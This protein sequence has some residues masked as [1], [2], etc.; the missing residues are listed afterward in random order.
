MLVPGRVLRR[1][2]K[3][4]RHILV[5]GRHA[6]RQTTYVIAGRALGEIFRP[7]ELGL[8][9]PG[10]VW[11][12]TV[13]LLERP[14]PAELDASTPAELLTETWRRLFRA[15]VQTRARETLRAGRVDDPG[16]RG[17]VSRI[18]RTEF[19]EARLVFEQDGW[20]LPP[21]DEP[22]LYA[23]LAGHF[24]ELAHFVPTLL[25][26]TFPAIEN[27]G[28]VE[29][30]FAGDVGP[31]ALMAE[32]RPAGA[33][34][35]PALDR[36]ADSGH[37]DEE[38]FEADSGEVVPEQAD[39]GRV[40]EHSGRD[41]RLALRARAAAER[42]NVVRAALLWTRVANQSARL[43]G[44]GR[45]DR[46]E[47]R[48]ALRQLAR[49]LRAALGF[50]ESEEGVWA[51]A[52]APLLPHAS[53]GF[54]GPEALLLHDLQ[55][56][57]LDHERLAYRLD[58]VG[59]LSSL[60]RNPLKNPLPHLRE[61]AVAARLRQASK[62]LP[63]VRLSRPERARLDSLVRS[64]CSRAEADLR[65]RIRPRIE[66]VLRETW[67]KPTNL[68][69]RVALTKLVE[70]LL[71]QVVRNGYLTLGD[72]RD[73]ASRSDLKVSDLASARELWRG[74]R[75]LKTDQALAQALDGVHHRGEIY[76][77]GL[78]RL[79][80]LAFGTR[81]GRTFTLFVAL[82]FGGSFVALE[83]LQ[84]LLGALIH[85]LTGVEIPFNNPAAILVD[86]LVAMGM[87][88]SVP[89]R[90][91]T[92]SA[93]GS[94]G[95]AIRAVLIEV[96]ARV[97]NAPFFRW[98]LQTRLAESVVRWLVKPGIAAGLA[99]GIARLWNV[100]PAVSGSAS[101]GAFLVANLIVNTRVGRVFEEAFQEAAARSWRSFFHDVLPGL[102]RLVMTTFGS[103]LQAV[104]RLLYAVDEWLQFRGGESRLGLAA[105]ALVGPV[106][107]AAAYLARIYVNVLIE[108]QI[109]PIKHFPV[110]TVSHKVILPMTLHLTRA[111]EAAI[112]PVLGSTFATYFAW[113]S[114]FLLPGMFGFL[115]WELKSNWRLYEAN[116][117]TSLQPVVVGGHGETV[118]NF[119]RPGFH[120]GTLPKTFARLRRA[121]RLAWISPRGLR[122]EKAA[123][124]QR[125]ALHHVEEALRRFVERDALAL[126]A[127]SRSL[128]AS[129][130]TLG[131]IRL[132]TN[133][134]RI[135]LLKPTRDGGEGAPL[136]VDIEERANVLVAGVAESGWL[137]RL[138]SD[139]RRTLDDALT[140]LFKKSGVRIVQTP[141][142]L[143][144]PVALTGDE[145]ESPGHPRTRLVHFDGIEVSWRDWVEVWES[146]LGGSPREA[147]LAGVLP[148]EVAEGGPVEGAPWRT[149][150]ASAG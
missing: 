11:P 95:R 100:R 63:K 150:S 138:G 82:P 133:R 42:G 97:L 65:G 31:R 120:S 86:G 107:F 127:G 10:D 6:G 122:P 111:M 50:P 57:C 78:Q 118:E 112:S 52:L 101:I 98:L 9:V 121:R 58:L 79:S 72:L 137:D 17:R 123:L 68:P 92:F 88:N 49:R 67:V 61:V 38:G 59:W 66:A 44:T 142:G 12:E 18:G 25:R 47:A 140:G 76:L 1:V 75:L 104:E 113:T 2:I 103:I 60:G 55:R 141:G 115:V 15:K 144:P 149:R 132:A 93:L 46:S 73:S 69:E 102:F 53:H 128:G 106:W 134:I 84:H 74:G 139:E 40:E 77:R 21:I 91:A 71:D 35:L 54:W 45:A 117:P 147:P 29:N 7:S 13:Y 96:P 27:P 83:G 89:F 33:P 114:V 4:D 129:G 34:E 109:N 105:K 125:A 23:L 80:M 39:N 48:G 145:P 148:V 41:R 143:I 20:L 36:A 70:E 3:R 64:A 119:L 62:R 28:A 30:V 8:N 51:E 87:I 110:V 146:E 22:D 14:D 126:L 99:W 24:L 16:L 116:R 19:E 130:I 37:D 26:P 135:E 43:R 131:E 81:T 136:V 124:K 90:S 85:W 94:I 32:T 56:A 5:L 108:P